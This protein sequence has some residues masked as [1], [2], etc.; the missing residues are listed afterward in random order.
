LFKE[1]LE[2][3]EE[4]HRRSLQ[5]NFPTDVR[6]KLLKE[7]FGSWRKGPSKIA[8][9]KFPNRCVPKI[10]QGRFWK[11]AKRSIEYRSKKI[12]QPMRVENCSR[13]VLGRKGPLKIAARKIPNRCPPK[14]AQGWFWKLTRKSIVLPADARRKFLKEG[15]GSWRRSPSKIAPRK[16]SNRC[17]PKIAQ[18]R[19]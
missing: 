18:G 10:A 8:P 9:R 16:F 2:V 13:K 3:G 11:L 6:P 5:E 17:A 4:V 14:I 19:F 12:S 7:G 1:G 15:F